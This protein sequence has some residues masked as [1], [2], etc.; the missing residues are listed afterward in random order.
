MVAANS[1]ANKTGFRAQRLLC[2]FTV[3]S[4]CAIAVGCGAPPDAGS[5]AQNRA[6]AASAIG[7]SVQQVQE[8]ASVYCPNTAEASPHI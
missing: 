5:A 1:R 7:E 3:L 8:A 2:R 6:A 4:G